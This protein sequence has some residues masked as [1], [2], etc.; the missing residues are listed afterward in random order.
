M[1]KPN[2]TKLGSDDCVSCGCHRALIRS[3]AEVTQIPS[4]D[5]ESVSWPYL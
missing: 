5:G 3:R 2:T 1:V 4:C